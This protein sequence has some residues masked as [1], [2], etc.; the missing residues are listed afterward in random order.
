MAVG[1]LVLDTWECQRDAVKI[2]PGIF[3]K[4]QAPCGALFCRG[5]LRKRQKQPYGA[6]PG[7]KMLAH[8]KHPVVPSSAQGSR[9]STEHP[10]VLSARSKHQLPYGAQ[11]GPEIL[12]KPNTPRCPVRPGDL[13]QATRTL[14]FP[15]R[16]HQA[17]YRA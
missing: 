5:P 14:R 6:F 2:G 4:H 8:T 11:F 17:P 15:V 1:T 10:M 3:R 13:Q 7:P 16:K 12:R 9:A